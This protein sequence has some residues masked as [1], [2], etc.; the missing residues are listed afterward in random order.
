MR[1]ARATQKKANMPFEVIK[2]AALGVVISFILVVAYAF[3]LKEELLQTSSMALF[4]TVIKVISAAAAGIL[5]VRHCTKRLWLFGGIG[6]CVYTLF[7][8]AVFSLMAGNVGALL[9]LL[10]D[11][12]MGTLAGLLS[13][14]LL[15]ALK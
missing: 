7:A 9:P 6:G 1:T 11:L 10:S 2:G 15:Q 4:T 8:Y 5:T 12:L 14:M 13:V 3:A